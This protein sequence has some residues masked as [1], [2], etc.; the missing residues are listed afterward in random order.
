MKLQRPAP[1]AAETGLPLSPRRSKSESER[2]SYR[3]FVATAQVA[4]D[5]LPFRPRPDGRFWT[6]SS[7][8]F[9]GFVRRPW[10]L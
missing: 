5:L 8:W 6:A 1:Q 7:A 3:E 10:C 9:L 4:S 2:P